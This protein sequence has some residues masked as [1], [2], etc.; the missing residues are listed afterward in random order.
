MKV[1]EGWLPSSYSRRLHWGLLPKSTNDTWSGEDPPI[2][3]RQAHDKR[4]EGE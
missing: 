1:V 4:G 3:V 2:R